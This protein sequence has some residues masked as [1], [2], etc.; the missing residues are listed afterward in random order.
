MKEHTSLGFFPSFLPDHISFFCRL[1]LKDEGTITGLGVGE[2]YDRAVQ[3]DCD[4]WNTDQA[5]IKDLEP[6]VHIEHFTAV[7]F[8]ESPAFSKR[9]P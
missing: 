1:D 5:F 8:D 4:G 9:D 6:W 2:D 7:F 3:T